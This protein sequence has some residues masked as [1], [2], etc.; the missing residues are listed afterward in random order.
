[1]VHIQYVDGDDWVGLYIDGELHAQG[2]RIDSVAFLP[3]LSG[4]E[5][6]FEEVFLDGNGMESLADAG[7]FPNAFPK[8]WGAI[9]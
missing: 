9:A 3:Y 4:I 7:G 6:S 2:H 8:D 1:M 5:F